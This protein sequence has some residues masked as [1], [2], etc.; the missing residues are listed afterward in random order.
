MKEEDQ[1]M[2]QVGGQSVV[3]SD[4]ASM[5]MRGILKKAV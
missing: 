2:S 5:E 4:L 1:R 3:P